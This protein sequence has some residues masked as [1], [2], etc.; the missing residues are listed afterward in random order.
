MLSNRNGLQLYL[1]K[2][3]LYKNILDSMIDTTVNSSCPLLTVSPGLYA[4]VE[5]PPQSEVI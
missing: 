5:E 4:D 1:A 2:R 3:K